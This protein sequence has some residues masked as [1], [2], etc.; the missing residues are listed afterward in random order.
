MHVDTGKSGKYIRH[1]LRDSF[2]VDGKVKHRTIANIS[3]CTPQEIEAIKLA[4]QH[5][6]DLTALAS[7]R[8]ASL[9]QGLSCGAVWVVYDLARQLGIQAALGWPDENLQNLAKNTGG[10]DREFVAQGA[11][12][13]TGRGW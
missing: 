4:L 11:I 6:G 3:H 5:K 7:L 1:L 9:Q 13:M 2:R 8:D 12:A 10:V